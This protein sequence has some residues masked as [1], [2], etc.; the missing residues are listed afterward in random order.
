M[1]SIN[2]NNIDGAYPI[3][4]QDN[5]SQGFRDNFTNI[6]TNFQFASSEITDLA[7]KVVLKQALVGGVLN[8]DFAGTQLSNAAISGISEIRRDF[9]TVTGN[10][11]VSFG[12]G[13]Y[14]KM[15]LGGNVTL[16]LG[17]WVPSGR[18]GRMR[19]EITVSNIAHTVSFTNIVVGAG[20]YGLAG[21]KISFSKLGTYVFEL[22]S[23]DSAGTVTIRDLDRDRR[24][25]NSVLLANATVAS[26]TP[27]LL[28][29]QFLAVAGK[30]YSFDASLFATHSSNNSASYGVRYSAGTGITTVAQQTT[31]SSTFSAVQTLTTSN[32]VAGSGGGSEEAKRV[33]VSGI[34]NNSTAADVLVDII[35]ATSGGTLTVLAGSHLTATQ[36]T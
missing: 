36:L 24:R 10:V 26:S 7:N 28:G 14:Q 35:F 18:N 21:S 4:G 19:L 33:N 27:A 12:D 22:E 3:A 25:G 31:A 9:T 17:G 5:D 8:N 23:D 13:H 20:V 11:T 34:Y 29:L 30:R 6:R 2:P 15:T 16:T 1:S 32:A